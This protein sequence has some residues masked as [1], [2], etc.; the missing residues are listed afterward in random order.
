MKKNSIAISIKKLTKV[1][2]LYHRPVDILKEL[3]FHKSN[4]DQFEALKN[5]NFEIKKGEV[6]GIIG[7]NGSGKSTLLKIIA[8][9]LDKTEGEIKINGKISAVLDLGLGFSPEY[10]GRENI[11]NG[12]MILGMTKNQIDQKIQSIIEFSELENF[13]DRPFKTYSSGMQ[14]RLTFSVA[15]AQEPEIMIIDEA[16]AAG[17][18][19]FISKCMDKIEQMCKSGTTVLFV[20]HSLPTVQKLCNR[21]IYLEN[22]KVVAD[23]PAVSVCNKYQEKIMQEISQKLK[24]ENTQTGISEKVI[25]YSPQKKIWKRKGPI[26]IAR[27]VFLDK[28]N[29]EKY[30]FYQNDSVTLRLY[31]KAEKPLKNLSV[32][33]IFYRSDGVCATSYLSCIPYQNLG[34]FEKNG[35]VDMTWENIY[36]GEDDYLVSCGI[37]HY[38]KNK[39]L[40]NLPLDSYVW[41]DKK[42]KIKITAKIW[43]LMSVYEQPVKIEHHKNPKK[44]I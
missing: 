1:Y 40:G 14:A 6:V 12:A 43:P 4:H 3:I 26:D 33:A 17:D 19:Y 32:W 8:G 24:I 34:T 27:V 44:I 7:K 21:A 39:P 28:N 16:L 9:T 23:G 37:Y 36:L 11:Y 13:I 18:M 31:Y 42:Y 41:H 35:Y 5:I 10:T 22:G 2:K 38:Q 15:T 20:S 29:Q 25:D 30:A